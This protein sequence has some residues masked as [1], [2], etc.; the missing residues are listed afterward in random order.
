VFWYSRRTCSVLAILGLGLRWTISSF[1]STCRSDIV[2]STLRRDSVSRVS[3]SLET[4]R[5]FPVRLG[6]GLLI[7]LGVAVWGRRALERAGEVLIG[8][9]SGAG[10]GEAFR[11]LEDEVVDTR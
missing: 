7:D 1:N 10:D 9:S 2:R 6:L 11:F 3:S 8:S 5:G 4:E